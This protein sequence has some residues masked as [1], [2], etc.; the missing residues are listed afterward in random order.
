M[1]SSVNILILLIGNVQTLAYVLVIDSNSLR[2]L[3][4][5]VLL[6][7]LSQH[8]RLVLQ[9]SVLQLQLTLQLRDHVPLNL[10][11][12]QQVTGPTLQARKELLELRQLLKS[13]QKGINES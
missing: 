1:R 8:S 10:S 6:L 13:E 5:S 3:Q 4:N 2:V 9:V 11:C 12:Q 7:K